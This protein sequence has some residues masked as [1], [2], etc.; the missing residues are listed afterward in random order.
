MSKPA[1]TRRD[2]PP[3]SDGV[4]VRVLTEAEV[5]AWRADIAAK[6]AALGQ[7]WEASNG[8]DTHA[9]LGALVFCQTT[10]P[11]WVFTAFKQMLI[12]PMPQEPSAHWGRW[13]LVREGRVKGMSLRKAYDYASTSACLIGP[14]YAGKW[15]AMKDSY[16]IVQK[17]RRGGKK[18]VAPFRS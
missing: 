7:R 10:L 5:Q 2:T 18:Q 11:K 12:E 15:R 8:T 3:T 16:D 17:E 4:R 14:P 9:L 6:M 13:L 1:A